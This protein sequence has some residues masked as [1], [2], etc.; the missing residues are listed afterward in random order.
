MLVV[1]AVEAVA[2]QALAPP[3]G[4]DGVGAG[5]GRQAGVEGGVKAG[6]LLQGRPAPPQC[7]DQAQHLGIVQ[8]RQGIELLQLQAHLGGD[9]GGGQEA[10][11][12]MH[13]PVAHQ[14]QA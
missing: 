3:A 13:Q 6:P 10:L 5:G 1:E 8:R 2:A 9:A 12:A 14:G 7:I 4:R 11:A